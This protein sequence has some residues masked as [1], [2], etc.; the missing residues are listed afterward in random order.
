MGYSNQNFYEQL[1]KRLKT[2]TIV[3]S[4][5]AHLHAVDFLQE[6][7][8]ADQLFKE[9]EEGNIQKAVLFGMPLIKKWA[10]YRKDKPSYYLSDNAKCYYYS[11]VDYIL[12]DWYENLTKTRQKNIAPLICGFN[13]TDLNAVHQIERLLTRYDFWKGIGEIQFRHDDLTNLT[14][15]EVPRPNHPAMFPIYEMCG[16]KG[17][18]ILV[19]QNSTTEWES[20]DIEAKH[21][22][23]EELTEVLDNFPKTTFI[24]AH[25]GVSR[26]THVSHYTGKLNEMLE[27]YPQL[28]MDISWVVYDNEITEGD[29][30][31]KKRW[32]DLFEKYPDRFFLGSDLL[33]HYDDLGRSM[34]RYN[35]LLKELSKETV[36]LMAYEN[37]NRMWFSNK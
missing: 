25:C 8:N 24:W 33:G 2:K 16:A 19:H 26:R 20:E 27:R 11:A 13:P 29:G 31:T 5:D 36:K 1:H 37:A 18:P 21:E 6:G 23:L 14:M 12:A 9:M 28:Y 34:G 30:A 7:E 35:T 32:L 4:I 10:Y 17:L 15:G 22:Y 3:P